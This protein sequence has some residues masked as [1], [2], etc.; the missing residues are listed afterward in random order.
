AVLLAHD[1]LGDV[2]ELLCQY[3]EEIVDGDDADQVAVFAHDRQPAHG[4][5]AHDFQSLQYAFGFPCRYQ[6]P[7]HDVA[8]RDRLAIESR[9]HHRHHDIA[10]GHDAERNA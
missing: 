4:L 8:D 1:D 2:A 5:V 10:V 9:S 6:F 3:A 7:P